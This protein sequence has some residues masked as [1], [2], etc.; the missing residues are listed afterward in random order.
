MMDRSVKVILFIFLLAVGF[1]LLAQQKS[2]GKAAN[3]EQ[4]PSNSKKALF[5][6]VYLGRSEF[7]G[8]AIS[9]AEFD[10]L[11]KQGLTSSDS[12]GNKYKVVDFDFNYIER[13]LFEDSIGNMKVMTEILYEHCKGDTI[14]R[15]ISSGIYDR[16][17]PG[18]TV[19][20]DQVSVVRYKPGKGNKPIFD[21]VVLGA[22][23]IK[24]ILTK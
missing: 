3:A 20:I 1:H 13:E 17:K 5:P 18:D 9:K 14:T 10:R 23:G 19:Y 12:L 7:K 8:G 11:L 22:R 2:N 15:N 21:S 6:T 24:C 16:S 4:S